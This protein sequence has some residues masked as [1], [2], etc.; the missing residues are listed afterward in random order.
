MKR[1][2]FS[3]L[4]AVLLWAV[5][6]AAAQDDRLSAEELLA[7]ARK[8][9]ASVGNWASLDGE[10]RHRRSGRS[11]EKMPVY[12]GI[13]FTPDRALAQLI[14]DNS[15]GYII[16][17]DFDASG[18]GGSTTPMG[19]YPEPKL[20]RFGLRPGDLTLSFIYWPLVRE[21]ES[22]RVRG[23]ACR[24]MMFES[25]SWTGLREWVRCSIS[26]EYGY[27]LKAEW[28]A[29]PE[30]CAAGRDPLRTLEVSSFRSEKTADGE[31]LWVVGE[32]KLSGNGWRTIVTFDEA[33]VGKSTDGTF[34][35]V[36]RKL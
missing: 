36:M 14:V 8:P 7:V 26:E 24:D 9:R 3:I 30:V 22:S 18:R 4:S 6:S 16:G 12:L 23:M 10:A 32:L 2:P 33:K 21:L 15:E 1:V 25:P 5:C 19:H 31:E 11:A 29:S 34:P 13:W 28:Y 20:D 17:Q 27:P 35:E